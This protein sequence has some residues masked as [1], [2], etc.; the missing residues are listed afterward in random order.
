MDT[1][2]PLSLHDMLPEIR[3]PPAPRARPAAAAAAAAAAAP[4]AASEATPQQR[5][6]VPAGGPDCAPDLL[7]PSVLR[8]VVFDSDGVMSGTYRPLDPA[9]REP[10]TGLTCRGTAPSRSTETGPQRRQEASQSQP[11]PQPLPKLTPAATLMQSLTLL[12]QQLAAA[13][14]A[15]RQRQAPN[16]GSSGGGERQPPQRLATACALE[17]LELAASVPVPEDDSEDDMLA[18]GAWFRLGA[19]S[20]KSSGRPRGS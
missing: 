7:D 8:A 20:G 2:I 9:Q 17:A 16:G 3:A 14:L 6:R 13:A 12:Q 15:V 1:A 19:V 5:K 10:L 4:A 11:M 18:R